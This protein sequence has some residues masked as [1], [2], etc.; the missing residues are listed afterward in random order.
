M[1]IEK[2]SPA[3]YFK[4]KHLYRDADG[5]IDYLN[6]FVFRPIKNLLTGSKEYDKD[7]TIE[8]DNDVFVDGDAND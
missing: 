8:E 4:Q 6:R 1:D 7:F 5:F 3:E 2:S